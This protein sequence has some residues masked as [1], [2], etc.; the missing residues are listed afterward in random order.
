MKKFIIKNHR[1]LF[2]ITWFLIGIVQAYASE[3]MDDEAYYWLFSRYPDFGF[4]DHP[5][6]IAFV[7]K[8]GYFFFQNELGVR[9]LFLLMN[10]LSLFII[11]NLL[12][13]KNVFLFYGTS[14]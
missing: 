13:K 10:S 1:I 9:L 6:M 3:L 5:P 12:E 8:A 7:I 4:F 11:E 14:F 2:Y